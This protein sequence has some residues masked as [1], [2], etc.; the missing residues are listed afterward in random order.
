MAI[1]SGLSTS[2]VEIFSLVTFL[3]NKASTIPVAN[4]FLVAELYTLTLLTSLNMRSELNNDSDR[5]KSLSAATRS[6]AIRMFFIDGTKVE[7][8][9]CSGRRCSTPDRGY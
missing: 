7:V 8:L 4:Q 5:S 3:L 9:I 6:L 1:R 2:S